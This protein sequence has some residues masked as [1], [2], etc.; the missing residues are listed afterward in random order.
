MSMEHVGFLWCQGSS[1]MAFTPWPKVIERKIAER[2]PWFLRILGLF[3]FQLLHKSITFSR[4]VLRRSPRQNLGSESG[5]DFKH[6]FIFPL[7]DSDQSWHVMTIFLRRFE[8]SQQESLASAE[9]F[10]QR[11]PVGCR[12]F[13]L[14]HRGVR[15]RDRSQALKVPE[16]SLQQNWTLK[17]PCTPHTQN[18]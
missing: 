17:N 1:R 4:S 15:E 9:V 6:V 7:W 5:F 12:G 10:P 13:L 14:W 8:T 2:H 16:V 18:P 3:F 11:G